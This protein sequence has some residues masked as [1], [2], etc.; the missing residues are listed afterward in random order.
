MLLKTVA[1]HVA[2]AV[3]EGKNSRT[4]LS[5]Y[6]TY[7]RGCFSKTL[8]KESG[9]RRSLNARHQDARRQ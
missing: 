7:Q 2:N 6:L 5:A 8:K 9:D 4:Y 3:A 1:K